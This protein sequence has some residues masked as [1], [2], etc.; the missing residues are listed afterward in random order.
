M[1]LYLLAS[2]ITALILSILIIL[3][4]ISKWRESSKKAYLLFEQNKLQYQK[5][6]ELESVLAEKQKEK[7]WYCNVFNN[8]KDM[9]Y[10]HDITDDLLPGK[11]LDVNDAMCKNL[12]Y[13]REQ[14]V[15]MTP[16][17]IEAI[18]TPV[19]T[20]GYSKSDLAVLPDNYIHSQAYKL[21]TR[22]ARQ[23]VDR[24]IKENQI[25]HECSFEDRNGNSVP[26]S[27]AARIVQFMGRKVVMCTAQDI[28]EQLAAKHALYES[29]Q[30]FQDFFVHSPIGIA[31]YDAQRKMVDVNQSCLRMFGVPDNEQFAKFNIFDNSFMTEDVRQRM[32]KGESI[33]YEATIDFNDVI[34]QSL[35]ITSK[36]SVAHFSILINNMGYD[37]DFNPRGFCAQIQDISEHR[38][39]EIELRENEK[40]LRQAEKMEAI[41]SLAGGIAHDFNNILTPILGYAE[42][43]LRMASG[44]PATEKCMQGIIK[45][46]SRAKDLV[47]QILTYFRKSDDS[48]E[49]VRPTLVTPIIKEV[50][51]LQRKAMSPEMEINRML[52]AEHD[53][54]MAN[55]TKIHQVFMNLCTNAYHA[56]R[57]MGKGTLEVTTSNFIMDRRSKRKF[58]EFKEGEYLQISIK[59]TGC[60]MNKETMAR[61]FEPFFTTKKKGEGTGMGLSV[62]QGIIKKLNGAISVESEPGKGSVFHVMLPTVEAKAFVETSSTNEILPTGTECILLVDDEP[63]VLEMMT[64]MLQSIHYKVIAASTGDTALRLFRNNPDEFNFVITDQAMPGITGM[65]LAAEIL[66]IRSNIPII[67]VTGFPENISPEKTQSIGIRELIIKPLILSDLAKIIRRELDKK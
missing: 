17:D 56:M 38:Q 65:E 25:V 15:Q 6:I 66:S 47:N 12:K 10:V 37:N 26:V 19:A 44:N 54:V 20:A 43:T 14:L 24:L 41:G 57:D 59:D 67:L 8:T 46:G 13:T 51:A 63:D 32:S 52:K 58:P 48:E 50:L 1:F 64:H 31:I 34:K 2:L 49:E 22:N 62:V 23:L 42:L 45:A 4:F 33:K 5:N 35:F 55:A 16:M 3:Y 60:G 39:A 40:Q 61:I 53:T 18:D 36:T 21:A 9:V 11:F 29:R 27:I 7:E 30:R 28:S